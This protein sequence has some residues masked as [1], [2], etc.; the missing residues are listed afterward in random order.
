MISFADIVR[1]IDTIRP[2]R[3]AKEAAAVPHPAHSTHIASDDSVP[4]NVDT[5]LASTDKL[6]A[7]S[8]GLV[9]PD[10]RD[11]LEFRRIHTPEK[12]FRERVE[13]DAGKLRQVAMRR[14]SKMRNLKAIGVAH[15]DPQVEGLIIGNPLSSPLEEINPL[16]LAEQA[17]RI[18]SMGPGGL[19][20][21]ESITSESQNIHPS[22]FGFICPI[23][24][25]ES[26]KIGVDTRMAWGTK[27]GN[28]GNL[29][30]RFKNARTGRYHWLAPRDLVNHTI[31]LPD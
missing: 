22:Q 4:A 2:G 28:D 8:R 17:R 23:S 25:P 11:S 29:Y 21:E 18:T 19:P 16:H 26:A 1:E 15:F 31:G 3:V 9:D 30:Q 7:V 6:L 13:L 20:G 12:L 24:G 27:I 14:V 5:I 10:E